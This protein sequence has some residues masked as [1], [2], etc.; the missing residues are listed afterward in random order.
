MIYKKMY[1]LLFNQMTEALKA[2]ENCDYGQAAKILRAA[3]IEAEALYIEGDE[4]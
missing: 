3:Q 4:D 2:I 1:F